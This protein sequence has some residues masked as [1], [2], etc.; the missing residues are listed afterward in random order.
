MQATN[1]LNGTLEGT[2]IVALAAG[3]AENP[4]KN[5]PKAI[6]TVFYRILIFYVGGMIVIGLL[7]PYTSPDLLGG[8]GDA[9]SS[10]FVIAINFAGISILPDITNAVILTAVFSAANSDVCKCF[11]SYCQCF[12]HTMRR[13]R[14]TH[15]SSCLL[16]C[17]TDAGS[18]ILFGLSSDQMAPKIFSQCTKKGIPFVGVALTA[19][20]G[21]LAYLNVDTAGGTAFL[22]FANI[23]SI[24]G[25]ITWWSI[26]L[27]SFH[28]PLS[29][30]FGL[31]TMRPFLL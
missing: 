12:P 8:T 4:R 15:S 3:E 2:E 23:S 22:W 25:I 11:L 10:P 31:T 19:L 27:V 21:L 9:T 18:R 7:V 6:N 30:F 24:T 20:M 26:L 14:G 29:H 28:R 5:V 16:L 13:I 17:S 1:W